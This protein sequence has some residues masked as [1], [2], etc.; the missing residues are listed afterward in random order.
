MMPA[1]NLRRTLAATLIIA[2]VAAAGCNVG[3]SYKAPQTTLPPGFSAGAPGNLADNTLATWWTTFK[4]PMLTSLVERAY[5]SNLDLRIA[6]SRIRQA[7]AQRGIAAAGGG[8]TL[9]TSGAYSRQK[10]GTAPSSNSFQF[11]FDAAWEIDIFGGVRRS[12]EAADA[13]IL[14]AVETR[15]DV[16]VTL[17]GEIAADYVTLRT[18]QQRIAIAKRNIDAQKHSADLTKQRFDAGLA[19]KLDVV[20]AE[21]LVAS[22]QSQIPLLE[23]SGRQTIYA[24]SVLLDREPASLVEELSVEGAIPAGAPEVPVGV[25]SDLLRR[26]PDIRAAE[27]SIHAATANIGVA[28]ADLYPKFTLNGTLSW[29][30]SSLGNWFNASSRLWSFGPSVSWSIFDSGRIRSNI[31]LQN[32]LTEQS[33]VTYRQIVL[34]ALEDV[35]NAMIASTKEAEHRKS[36]VEAAEANRKAVDLATK[37]YQDGQTDFLSVLD[38]ERS[39]YASEDALIQS[40]GSMSTDLIALYKALGGGWQSTTSADTAGFQ[41]PGTEAK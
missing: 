32:A 5:A 39:L 37:L 6:E 19:S 23:S 41:P 10:L 11:G 26:R 35:E 9:S 12:V 30:A 40:T 13:N 38:A 36:L 33:L 24:L 22:T 28:T 20:N 7:R 27:A 15:R 29:Q 8:P 34:T 3:P 21:A 14:S 1:L 16:L 2:T 17:A 18:T 31:E 25:P 4:D